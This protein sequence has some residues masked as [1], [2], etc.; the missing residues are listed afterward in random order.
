LAFTLPEAAQ[1]IKVA[2][3][4]VLHEPIVDVDLT[5]FQKPYFIVT[6]KWGKTRSV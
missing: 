3:S 1:A 4:K 2:Y 6:G 5:E